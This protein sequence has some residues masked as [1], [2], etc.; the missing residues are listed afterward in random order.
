MWNEILPNSINTYTYIIHI[1]LMYS[2]IIPLS[3]SIAAVTV[4]SVESTSITVGVPERHSNDI[5]KQYK[6]L[7]TTEKYE[8]FND[9]GSR[10]IQ[11]R[12]SPPVR[13]SGLEEGAKYL[14]QVEPITTYFFCVKPG[15]VTV[16]TLSTGK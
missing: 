15:H 12:T 7:Y 9:T 4:K 3:F 16:T 14:I 11:Y 5:I 13:L 8:E 2:I 1:Y 10:L 6:F